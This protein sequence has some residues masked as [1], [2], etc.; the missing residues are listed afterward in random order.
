MAAAGDIA[1][2]TWERAAEMTT[3]MAEAGERSQ[4]CEDLAEECEKET[5][6]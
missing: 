4:Q 2:E 5:N 3:E 1:A 6:R